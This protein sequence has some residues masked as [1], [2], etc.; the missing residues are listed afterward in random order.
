L[1]IVLPTDAVIVQNCLGVPLNKVEMLQAADSNTT[2][3]KKEINAKIVDFG[4][5]KLDVK[6]T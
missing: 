6:S 3:S 2:L 1:L 5:L 4:S